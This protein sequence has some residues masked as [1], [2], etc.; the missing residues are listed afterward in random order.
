MNEIRL[1]MLESKIQT[2]QKN[3]QY[4]QTNREKLRARARE[5]YKT[6]GEAQGEYHIKYYKTHREEKRIHA[7]TYYEKHLEKRKEYDR[8]YLLMHPEKGKD[9]FYKIHYG[10]SLADYH[11]MVA[12]QEKKC[13]ICG[14][15][16]KRKLYI[17]HDHQ[18]TK[19]R[20]LIC[21]HCNLGLGSFKDN[22]KIL[23]RAIDYL[24]RGNKEEGERCEK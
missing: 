15:A 3:A 18:T 7:H 13:S 22:P 16:P 23:Q 20:G 6:H 4:Y 19:F 17:D 11:I 5:Y 8:N 21:H 9:N 1:N 24:T 12:K 10:I 14:E 2:A